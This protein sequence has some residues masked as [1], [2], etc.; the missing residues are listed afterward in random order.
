MTLQKKNNLKTQPKNRQDV[1]NKDTFFP[2]PD[3]L[4]LQNN[5]L[6]LLK[7]FCLYPYKGIEL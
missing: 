5:M 7:T 6:K 4:L 2:P 3:F 1:Q